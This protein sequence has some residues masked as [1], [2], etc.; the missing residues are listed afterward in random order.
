MN[1]RRRLRRRLLWASVLLGLLALLVVVSVV[2]ACAW[3]RDHLLTQTASRPQRR[4]IDTKGG[5]MTRTLTLVLAIALAAVAI[6]PVA[7]GEQRARPSERTSVAA[8]RDAGERLATPHAITQRPGRV[9]PGSTA[10][11]S[12]SF[13][14]GNALATYG[15]SGPHRGS[16]TTPPLAA[17]PTYTTVETPRVTS[18]GDVEWPQIGIGVALGIAVAIGVAISL[19]ALRSRPLAH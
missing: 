18:N 10:P 14:V 6:A 17:K 5:K 16:N 7:L 2:R 4:A 1:R 12:S 11:H 13:A 8:Y 15:D 3:G 19:Q 9:V